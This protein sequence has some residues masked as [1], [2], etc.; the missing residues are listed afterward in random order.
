MRV[1]TCDEGKKIELDILLDVAKFCDENNLQY[2]LA[3]GTLL[4]AIRHKGFIPW[5]DDV[6]INMPR[7]DYNFL[8]E[9]YNQARQG[10]PYRLIAPIDKNSRHSI[11]KVIDTR[12]VKKEFDV[13]DDAEPLGIDIDIFPL[14]GEP[15]SK[16]EF[17]AWYDELQTVYKWYR[18]SIISTK[19]SLKRKLGIPVVKL[20]FGGKKRLLKKAAKLHGKYPYKDSK[21]VGAIE[22][23]YNSRGNRFNKEWFENTV[24][25]EFEGHMLKCPC[26]YHNILSQVYG[27]Y[28]QLP[29]LDK[30]VTHH[31]NEMYWKE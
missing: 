21:Y 2:F 4:G 22:C 24:E 23:A 13:K 10:T 7:D 6:D 14:D 29:P 20:V 26:G 8:M 25:L 16:E 27:D 9:N 1:I 18:Y 11:V 5:D 19:G 31:T 12:T 3:Y 17:D 15:S 30:Q 28:M